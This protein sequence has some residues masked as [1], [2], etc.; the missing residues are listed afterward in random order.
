[1]RVGIEI[2][3]TSEMN[4]KCDRFLT[5]LFVTLIGSVSMACG[6][7]DSLGP[8]QSYVPI[9]E[10]VHR[11]SEA[12]FAATVD[13]GEIQGGW[14][15]RCQDDLVYVDNINIQ[16]RCLTADSVSPVCDLGGLGDEVVIARCSR[17]CAD[18]ELRYFENVDDYLSTG[19][20]IVCDQSQ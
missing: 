11:C 18:D 7:A 8:E 19:P 13:C 3:I 16:Q 12:E 14:V 5:R 2:G 20:F 1:V 15:M 10:P 9:V 17:G 6:A 4:F